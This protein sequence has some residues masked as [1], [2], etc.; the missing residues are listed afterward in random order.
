MKAAPNARLSFSK[1]LTMETGGGFAASLGTVVFNGTDKQLVDGSFM[2][3]D[4]EFDNSAAEPG[5]EATCRW[6]GPCRPPA[7]QP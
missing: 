5:D 1:H 7:R 2:F 3:H 6:R 4:V